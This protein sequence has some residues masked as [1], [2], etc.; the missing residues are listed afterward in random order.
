MHG[1]AFC[2]R[3]TFCAQEDADSPVF[4]FRCLPISVVGVYFDVV[5]I[6]NEP[7]CAHGRQI[8]STFETKGVSFGWLLIFLFH[9]LFGKLGELSMQLMPDAWYATSGE[10]YYIEKRKVV[11]RKISK[12]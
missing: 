6:G 1:N 12:R 3:E 2:G 10:L 7:G 8:V 11:N 9:W 5:E 4:C